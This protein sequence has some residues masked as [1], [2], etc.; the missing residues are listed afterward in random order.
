MIRASYLWCRQSG[1][2]RAFIR[3]PTSLLSSR[4]V[5]CGGLSYVT[6]GSLSAFYQIIPAAKWGSTPAQR[7]RWHTWTSR[8]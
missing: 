3:S 8:H 5:I 2:A 1:Q 4:G 7:C 6:A